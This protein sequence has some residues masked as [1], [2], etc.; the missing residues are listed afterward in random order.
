MKNIE[1]LEN[2]SNH[3][4]NLFPTNENVKGENILATETVRLNRLNKSPIK[5]DYKF[6]NELCDS[7]VRNHTH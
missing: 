5:S 6:K 2:T 7:F 3:E 4:V 1:L